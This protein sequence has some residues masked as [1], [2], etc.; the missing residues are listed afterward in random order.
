M[1]FLPLFA[2]CAG[3]ASSAFSQAATDRF[4]AEP[5][6]FTRIDYVVAMQP[7]GT[8]YRERTVA[9]R[10]QSEAAVHEFSVL[11]FGFAGAS[12]HVDLHY[13]RVRRAD[14]TVVETPATDA[15]EQPTAVTREAP[16]YSDQKEKQI[17]VRSLRVGDTLEW[18]V[19]NVRTRAE[20]PNEFW[21]EDRFQDSLVTLGETVELHVPKAMKLN[22]WTNPDEA[23]PAES[24]TGEERVYTWQHHN[25][26]PTVGPVAEVEKED[27][28]HHM[29]TPEEELDAREG[30]L[31][32]YGWSTFASWAAVGDWYRGLERERH[33]PDADIKAKVAELTAGKTTQE[34]RVQA[35][36]DYVALQVRYV[37]VAFGVGRYQPHAAGEVL[38]NQYGDCKDKHTLLAAML[39]ELGLKPDAVLIGA[40]VRFNDALPSPGAFNHLI[41][42]VAVDGKPVWLDA[43]SETAPYR[44][45]LY[46]IRD[47]QALVI[48][49]EGVA[50]LE[51]TPKD[52]PFAPFEKMTAVGAL[53]KDGVSESHLVLT[54]HGDE[55]VYLR[56]VL[57]QLSADKYEAFVQALVNGM[58][59]GGTTS[60]ASFSKLTDTT[61]PLAISFDYHREKA[62]DWDHYR[63]IPQLLPVG[64]GPV[65][66]KNPPKQAISLG[67][68]TTNT[69]TAEMKLPAGWGAELPQAVHVK[70]DFA[71]YDETYRLDKG[72]LYT[73]RKVSVLVERIPAKDWQKYKAWG[74]KVNLPGD[75]YIQL[76]RPGYGAPEKTDEAASEHAAELIRSAFAALQKHDTRTAIP[77]LKQAGELNAGQRDLQGAYGALAYEQ[78]NFNQAVAGYRLEVETHPDSVWVYAPMARAQLYLGKP[79]EAALSLRAWVHIEPGNPLAAAQLVALLNG[80]DRP[81]EAIAAAKQALET[82]P[83]DKRHEPS[84]L[85]AYGIAQ[86]KAGQKAEGSATL[87]TVIHDSTDPATLNSA[88]YELANYG[89][90]LPLA[91]TTERG[92]LQQLT[93]ATEGWTGDEQPKTVAAKLTTLYASWDT[94]GWILFREGK[95][96]EAADYVD[97][98]FLNRPIAEV[99]EHLGDIR[100]ALGDPTGAR[101]AYLLAIPSPPSS[102]SGRAETPAT[103]ARREGLQAKAEAMHKAGARV[104]PVGELA[105]LRKVNLGPAERRKFS[106]EYRLLLE[107]ASVVSAEPTGASSVRGG[108]EMILAMKLP[109]LFPAGVDARL[110]KLAI[111]NCHAE[112]CELIFEP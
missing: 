53:D 11:S 62:G 91:E 22:V 55:E 70:T 50:R 67:V 66:E 106:A 42:Q 59:Y 52:P 24:T 98:S 92:V 16:F 15:Q 73:E 51:R 89:Q 101:R 85:L 109:H 47:K 88:A 69:S 46:P 41:T 77:L 108:R 20:A 3:F 78:G 34:A 7:D 102:S 1:R 86:L 64:L 54:V 48:P 5:A 21:D 33:T 8:G 112:T 83:E 79:D 104:E 97:A 72:T 93:T 9:V 12:E 90:E 99:G 35:V 29:L 38:Q 95:L 71:T 44:M 43:T 2:L 81:E 110:V 49:D 76:T 65:D 31:P 18:Q 84:F 45:L 103:K 87:K 39:T 10:I 107:P 23:R 40:G 37:G 80:Q 36:Y 60:H 105:D 6:V 27:K 61:V 75:L 17:P 100:A 56:A 30:M 57:R 94:M 32:S 13:V 74:D 63:I 68:P 96:K 26:K 19:R 82:L 14:G 25:L 4:A 28:K 58:G 111:L